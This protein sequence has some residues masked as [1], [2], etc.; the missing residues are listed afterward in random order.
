MKVAAMTEQIL[1]LFRRS[2]S[3][4]IFSH[5]NPDG[6]AL[7]SSAGLALTLNQ[8]GCRAA[9]HLAGSWSEHLGFLL[10]GLE[11][12]EALDDPA[13]YDLAVLLDCHSF[14]RLGPGGRTVAAKLHKVSP[15]IPLVVVDHHLL[16]EGEEVEKIWVVRPEVSSTGEL[17]WELLKNMG[18]TPPPAAL[19]ALLVA[20]ATDTGFFSQANT[21][22]GSLR[23]AA[24]LVALGGDLEEVNRR[25]RETRPLRALK[26]KGAVLESLEV[27]FDGRM[28]VMRV[29]P[30][31]LQAAGA[32]MADT[33][34][35]VEMGRGLTGVTLAAL[36][37][38]SGKGP[39]SVRVS[40]RSRQN[41]DAQGLALLFGG[42]GHRQ[43]AAYNDPE[44]A[45]AA[46][47]VSNLLARADAF[48]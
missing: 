28:A 17:V 43:A 16:V 34:N 39:G 40:L 19:Q 31:M 35:F 15:S 14:D 48:L 4:I 21:T 2:K 33:E 44:A 27:R 8:Y 7:G 18:Y 29:T 41:I 37:K 47:A 36:V 42:G 13:R 25:V 24:D 3:A 45:D 46:E 12:D 6:D 26:L 32:Q 11:V 30:E 5:H 10:D 9:L 20:I 22:P 23:S 38:D 1:E